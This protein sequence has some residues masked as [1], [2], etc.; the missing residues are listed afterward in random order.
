MDF[1]KI[2]PA[3]EEIALDDIQ[4]AKILNACKNKKR[5]F[6]YKPIIGI[7]AAAAVVTVVLVSPG[8]LFKASSPE[9]NDVAADSAEEGKGS[10]NYLV[11]EDM[12][13]VQNS[14]TSSGTPL[15][16]A[17]EYHEIYSIIPFE[18][19]S[20][21]NNEEYK[22]WSE[23]V[24]ADGGMAM[25]QFVLDFNIPREDFE[26]AFALYSERTFVNVS[27]SAVNYDADIIYSFDRE[28]IDNYYKK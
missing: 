26:T 18:F 8:F 4:K 27:D 21:V 20:L 17:D 24:T 19:S 28:T 12:I 3:V 23:K 25:A 5:K 13:I 16:E 7:A 9:T 6:N 2:K 14:S 1:E 15:F 11:E 10:F 22:T